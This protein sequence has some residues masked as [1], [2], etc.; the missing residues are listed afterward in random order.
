M[1]QMQYIE[2]PETEPTDNGEDMVQQIEIIDEPS[3]DS[4]IKWAEV[5]QKWR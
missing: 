5:T 1:K 4:S 2:N 3:V